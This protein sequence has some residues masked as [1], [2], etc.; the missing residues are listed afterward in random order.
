MHRLDVEAFETI[1]VPPGTLHAIGEGVLLVEVQEPEDLSILCE[2][3]SFEIDGA[4]EGHLGLEFPTALTAI[5]TTGCTRGEIQKLVTANTSHGSV[6]VE[7]GLDYFDMERLNVDGVE[8]CRRG[9]AVLIVCEGRVTYLADGHKGGI[10]MNLVKGNTVVIPHGDGD[11]SV[12][13]KRLQ[14]WRAFIVDGSI[15]QRLGA[16]SREKGQVASG[17]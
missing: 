5:N 4:K 16:Y 3:E 9:F 2:W 15:A 8:N 17:T 1:Y 11:F 14:F 6:I 10:S 12:R 13:G 7:Q